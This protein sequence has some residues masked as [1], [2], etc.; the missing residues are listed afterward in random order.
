[1]RDYKFETEN[2]VAFIRNTLKSAGSEGI[3]Y[4]NSGGKDCALVGILCK[5][6]CENTL[7]VIMPCGSKRNFE[8]DKTHAE[9]FAK[10]YN[11][12]TKYIDLTA[13]KTDL[14]NTINETTTLTTDAIINIAP[15]LRM[16]ALYAIAA[17]EKRLVAGTSNRSEQ[18]MGYFTKWRTAHTILIRLRI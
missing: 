4:G 18:Y 11:I 1:M 2:R 16:T 13:I 7:G 5:M 10:L 14:L 3:V 17:S 15:R 6:A 12:A 9:D 8:D